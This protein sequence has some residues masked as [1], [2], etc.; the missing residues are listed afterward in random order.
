MCDDLCA[1]YQN[2]FVIIQQKGYWIIIRGAELLEENTVA[3]IKTMVQVK[4][5]ITGT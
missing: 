5:I 1:E 3:P 4:L 2:Y